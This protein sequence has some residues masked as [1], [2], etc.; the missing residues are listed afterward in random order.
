MEKN[1]PEFSNFTPDGKNF[2]RLQKDSD[3]K[4]I[5]EA[6]QS[7]PKELK[8]EIKKADKKNGF[9][10]RD[11]WLIQLFGAPTISI[12]DAKVVKNYTTNNMK[13]FIGIS[14]VVAKL[15]AYLSKQ[16]IAIR[17]PAV[18]IGNIISNFNLSCSLGFSPARVFK[19]TVENAKNVREYMDN[20]K[21]LERIKYK[22]RIGTVTEA[23]LKRV[24]WYQTKLE[25]NPVH[26]LMEKGFYQ[27]IVEDISMDDIE[28]IGKISKPLSRK[29]KKH[30]IAKKVLQTLFLLEGNPYFDFMFQ[31][32]QYSDFIARATHYQLMIEKVTALKTRT[33]KPN[34]NYI[35]R[36]KLDSNGKDAIDSKGHK[37]ITPEFAKFE[38]QLTI[39][40]WNMFINYDKPQSS[41]E[42]YANDMGLV[43][44]TKFLKRVQHIIAK[45]F[46]QSPVSSLLFLLSQ[47]VIHESPNI[48]DYVLPTRNLMWNV[49]NPLS[50]NFVNAAIPVPI[51]YMTDTGLF[52]RN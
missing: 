48:Y 12:N 32:T 36:Y 45:G 5:R 17:L 49:F 8:D 7:L 47:S 13:Y 34:P 23:E 25:S 21:A 41:I 30:P 9:W 40:I 35:Q 16:N 26:P 51:Q 4:F 29:L 37:I 42:Q 20:K 52:G 19:K 33:G 22:Q 15:V 11:E 1:K 46:I 50:D 39:D 27:S 2:V 38:K 31:A 28:S 10:V 6:W 43:M 24:N 18:L 44:F 3:N 14:E